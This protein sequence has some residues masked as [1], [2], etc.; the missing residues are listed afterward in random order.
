[1][2]R[3]GTRY[4][5]R[6]ADILREVGLTQDDDPPAAGPESPD[7]NRALPGPRGPAVP[8]GSGMPVTLVIHAVVHRDGDL[9]VRP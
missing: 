6:K 7:G 4:R 9:W 5:V 8:T 1:M 3:I 2:L